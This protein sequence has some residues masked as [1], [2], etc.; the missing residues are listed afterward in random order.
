VRGEGGDSSIIS[1]TVLH[2]RSNNVPEGWVSVCMGFR[3]TVLSRRIFKGTVRYGLLNAISRCGICLVF[4]LRLCEVLFVEKTPAYPQIALVA[5][6]YFK[7]LK[8]K[9]L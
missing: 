8:F 6:S 2:S 9:T 5:Y 7:Y 4:V 1:D 3:K